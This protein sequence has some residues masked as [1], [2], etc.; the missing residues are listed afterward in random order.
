MFLLVN[1]NSDLPKKTG[2]WFWAAFDRDLRKE[3]SAVPIPI[4]VGTITAVAPA[5]CGETWYIEIPHPIIY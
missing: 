2:T 5:S 4:I 3:P 1:K